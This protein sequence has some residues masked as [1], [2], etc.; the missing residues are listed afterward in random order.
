M[1]EHT[2]PLLRILPWIPVA[3]RVKAQVFPV[4]GPCCLSSLS[5]PTLPPAHLQLFPWSH[6]A[7]FHLHPAVASI[8]SPDFQSALPSLISGL[9]LDVT[10]TVRLSLTTPREGVTHIL[11][12]PQPHPHCLAPSADLFYSLPTYCQLTC[13][14]TFPCFYYTYLKRIMYI[15]WGQGVFHSLVSCHN[16]SINNC[17]K[18]GQIQLPIYRWRNWGSEKPY[19]LSLVICWHSVD[20]STASS[21][22]CPF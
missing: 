15:A 6:Q 21:A 8:A 13:Y 19:A 9:C 18:S 2:S 16:H 20:T 22:H 17:L 4:A 12:L 1:R 3:L 14:C 5:N 10:P 7:C 11:P